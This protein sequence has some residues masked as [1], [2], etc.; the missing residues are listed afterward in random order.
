MEYKHII[1]SKDL[2]I[3]Q[4]EEPDMA[5]V[6]HV[7]VAAFDQEDEAKLVDALRLSDA[8]VPNLSLVAVYNAEII[9]HVMFTKIIIENEEHAV[10]SLAL[11]PVAVLPEFQN[12]KIGQQ[13]IDAGLSVAR[14]AGFRSVIVM[15]HPA[16][17]ARFGFAPAIKWNIKP[18]FDVPSENF[19]AIE[20]HKG[21]LEQVY[22]IVRYS[23]PFGIV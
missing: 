1:D 9:G 19:M 23:A 21:A 10:E 12:M 13:L 2:I 16:Y 22:G 11:A 15:G 4:E 8:Y 7:N 18:P 3:R 6:F 5:E 17:Y 14:Q 20:L